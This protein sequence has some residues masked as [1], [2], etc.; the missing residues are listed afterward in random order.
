[1]KTFARVVPLFSS[2]YSAVKRKL[3]SILYLQFSFFLPASDT[4]TILC[5]GACFR[6]SC[7]NAFS[8]HWNHSSLIDNRAPSLLTVCTGSKKCR[9]VCERGRKQCMICCW[10][11][12]A[13]PGRHRHC[14]SGSPWAS[15]R[16]WC[17]THAAIRQPDGGSH[18]QHR[19]PPLLTFTWVEKNRRQ[20]FDYCTQPRL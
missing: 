9:Q 2:S 7:V 4:N 6:S 17:A 15:G 3:L 10:A 8:C 13:C 16:G 11:P 18:Q 5:N 12:N 19:W 1:M 20:L 14:L